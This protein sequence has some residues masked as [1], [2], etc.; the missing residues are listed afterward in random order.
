M[1]N[2]NYYYADNHRSLLFRFIRFRTDGVV[3]G[4]RNLR[5]KLLV[6]QTNLNCLIEIR[7]LKA[8]DVSPEDKTKFDHQHF[9]SK[10]TRPVIECV[11]KQKSMSHL[12][13]ATCNDIARV[14]F[15]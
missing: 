13:C 12:I 14:Y 10:K 3:T 8:R 6:Q 11:N 7:L 2:E 9:H 5:N 15:R 4:R 1:L